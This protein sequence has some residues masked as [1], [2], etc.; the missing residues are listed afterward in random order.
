MNPTILIIHTGGTISSQKHEAGA[1]SVSGVSKTLIRSKQI[2]NIARE[3]KI[4]L[5]DI[6]VF[7]KPSP[8]I[9][10][11]DMLSIITLLNRALRR[12]EVIGSIIIH[13]TDTMEETAFAV[14]LLKTSAKPVKFTGSQLLPSDAHFDGV[15]N[16]AFAI[17]RII[18]EPHLQNV[19]LC[20]GGRSLSAF[21][22]EKH[23]T[24]HLSPFENTTLRLPPPIENRM[25]IQHPFEALTCK[26]NLRTS[27]PLFVFHSGRTI[28]HSHIFDSITGLVIGGSG[29]AAI[30]S[31]L[32]P[33]VKQLI[34]SGI[35]VYVAPRAAIGEVQL[36]Y[37]GG[38]A[39]ALKEVGASIIYGL[40]LI[41]IRLAVEISH[42]LFPQD[43]IAR[44][45]FLNQFIDIL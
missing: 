17:D 14:E 45:A 16:I 15:Q 38:G 5:E 44:T 39:K 28:L 12:P 30:S 19:E 40:P 11:S 29:M 2:C 9:N 23:H 24:T 43:I 20:M 3:A 8:D 7:N 37:G 4:S 26:D 32:L 36:V 33:I 25:Q 22:A 35:P 27:I 42:F 21:G 6:E 18:T 13:G 1:E 34:E 10:F 31:D 41:Q